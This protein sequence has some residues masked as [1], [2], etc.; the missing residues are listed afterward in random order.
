MVREFLEGNNAA[1]APRTLAEVKR[2]CS[3]REITK[4]THSEGYVMEM[5]QGHH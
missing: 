1:P 2:G 3:L 5:I 4:G